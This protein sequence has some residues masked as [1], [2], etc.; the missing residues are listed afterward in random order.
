MRNLLV[1]ILGI[2]FFVSGCASTEPAREDDSAPVYD[3]TKDL[4]DEYRDESLDETERLLLRTRSTL[5]NHYTDNMV[6]I[7]DIF[8]Q[9]I[10]V[11]ERQRDPYAGFRVQLLSTRVVAEADSVRDDFVA[12]AD[13]TVSGY[14][15]DAYII[16]RSP[17]YRVRAGDFQNRDKAIQF[18]SLLKSKYPD[19]WV[20]HER[21]EPSNVPPDTTEI[22]L[23]DLH[24]LN[25]DEENEKID[26]NN[27]NDGD[28]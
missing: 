23:K 20:V 5:S 18:S 1:L 27:E 6:S 11:E 10:V 3:E 19:A 9:E 25:L 24:E 4:A 2:T 17:N 16:F 26:D 12:W 28:G 14:E 13:T 7:P 15:P 21:I 8:L 22:R